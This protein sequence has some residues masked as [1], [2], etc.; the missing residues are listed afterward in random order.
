MWMNILRGF[1]RLE[2]LLERMDLT[3]GEIIPQEAYVV[4]LREVP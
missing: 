3:A 2:R 1:P 4:C